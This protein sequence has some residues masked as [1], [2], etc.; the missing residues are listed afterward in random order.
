M[1]GDVNVFKARRWG[2]R[3]ERV[4]LKVFQQTGTSIILTV[5]K[6]GISSGCTAPS[7]WTEVYF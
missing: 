7:V 4:T 6:A 2:E 3:R 5:A 1:K